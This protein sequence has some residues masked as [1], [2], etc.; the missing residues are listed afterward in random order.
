MTDIRHFIVEYLLMKF[1]SFKF[2]FPEFQQIIE[3]EV[4]KVNLV[5]LCICNR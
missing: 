2:N 4:C 3:E 1:N 5:L